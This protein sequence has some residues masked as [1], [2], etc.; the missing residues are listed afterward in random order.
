M[1][2]L[3]TLAGLALVS[4]TLAACGA[5]ASGGGPAPLTPTSRWQLRAEPELDRIALAVH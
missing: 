4:A 2:A 3:K 1:R 5:P